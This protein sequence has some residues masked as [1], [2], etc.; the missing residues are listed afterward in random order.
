MLK[1]ILR[2]RLHKDRSSEELRRWYDPL[3]L[4]YDTATACLT[5]SFPHVHFAPWFAREGQAAFERAVIEWFGQQ[6]LAPALVY[7]TASDV[8]PPSLREPLRERPPQPAVHTLEDFITNNKNAFPLAA[9]RKVADPD[10]EQAY[11]PFIVCGK[12]GTGKTHILR[13]LAESLT[14]IYGRDAVFSADVDALAAAVAAHDGP[15]LFRTRQVLLVDDLQRI[16]RNTGLQEQLVR[17]MDIFL[18]TRRQMVFACAGALSSLN[19]LNEGLR[20]RLEVGL[21]VELK[22]PD[23]DVRLRYAQQHCRRQGLKLERDHLLLLAQRCAQLRYL[24]GILLK[25]RAFQTLEQR[26]ITT[27]DLENILRSS[28]D[29]RPATS[30]DIVRTVAEHLALTPRDIMGSKRHP[31]LVRARQLAMYLCR[32]LQGT[33]YP[34]LGR[35]FGGKDHSTVAHSIKKITSLLISDKDVQHLVTELKRKCSG[36]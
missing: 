4:E 11:N 18:D 3:L 19:G 6:G 10:S 26:A 34:A 32:E 22:E 5:V 21:V 9:A 1:D 28:G 31:A 30:D 20:S 35:F 17:I 25:I 24:S 14:A 8:H 36:R 33:S 7:R 29:T 12:S 16:V 2:D 23:L 27:A 13:A 15:T